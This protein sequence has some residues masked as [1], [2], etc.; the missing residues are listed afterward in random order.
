MQKGQAIVEFDTFMIKADIWLES[1]LPLLN[2]IYQMSE[3]VCR[4][5]NAE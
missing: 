2:G 1:S 5:G 3:L 4:C